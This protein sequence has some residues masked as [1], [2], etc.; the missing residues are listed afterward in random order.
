MAISVWRRAE[1]EHR[2]EEA[3]E[4]NGRD[5]ITGTAA[6][7]SPLDSLLPENLLAG[8]NKSSTGASINGRASLPECTGRCRNVEKR[9]LLK[10]REFTVWKRPAAGPACRRPWALLVVG[11]WSCRNVENSP[12]R[13]VGNAPPDQ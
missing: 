13:N 10:R 3:V 4:G 5:N 12:C 7:Y 1:R 11:R 6:P 8:R 9:A 2:T